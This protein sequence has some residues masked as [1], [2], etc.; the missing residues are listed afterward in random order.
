M[1]LPEGTRAS[2]RD[3]ERVAESLRDHYGAGRLS[4]EDLSERIESAYG[5]RTVAELAA[6]TAD[7]PP[8]RK[9]AAHPA[10]RGLEASVRVHLTIY[11]V[12]N[13]M[14]IG[15]WAAAGAGY[16]WPVWPILGWGI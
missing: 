8:K 5:A 12:V 1:S 4:E 14:L 9:P 10:R 6:L 2:D 16:F 11:L 3:R 13:A 7:L 15:I